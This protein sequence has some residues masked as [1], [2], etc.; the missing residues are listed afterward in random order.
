MLLTE[1]ISQVGAKLKAGSL[2]SSDLCALCLSRAKYI[3][4][5][6]AFVTL[7]NDH[8]TQKAE[9]STARH[10]RGI[11]KGPLDG[12]TLAVKDN[13][14]MKGAPTT[15]CSRMLESF[16][17]QYDATVVRKLQD[18]GAVIIG[19]CNMDEFA[20]G[21][22][23]VDSI[24]GP[25]KN[26]WRSELK[27]RLRQRRPRGET[28]SES[29]SA[30]AGVHEHSPSPSDP[31]DWFISGGSSGG[32]AVAVACGA[33]FAGIGSDTGGSTRNPAAYCGLVG[34]KPS[35]GLVSRHGLIPLVNSMDVPGILAR[36]VDDAAF[37]LGAVAGLDDLDSTTVESHCLS[38]PS[39]DEV[40][41]ERITVGIPSE[42]RCAGLSGDVLE[43]WDS[44]A[45]LLEESGAKVVQVSMPHTQLS[46]ACYSVLNQCEV[47]SNMARYDGIEFGLRVEGSTTEELFASTRSA[48]FNDV[49]RAR[50]LVGNYFLLQRNY[51]KYFVQAQ[52]IR[53][54]IARDF[55]EVWNSGVDV[56]LT[57]TTLT[58]APRY[59]EFVVDDN[60]TQCALQDYCTQPA[61]MAGV[62]A[63]TVPVK[64]SKNG[65]PVSLQLMA[66]HLRDG[67]LLTVAR[68]LERRVCFPVLELE[69]QSAA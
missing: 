12:I 39:Q 60:R 9:E 44:V 30:A 56:L 50:I 58:T 2:L 4:P 69:E 1:S 11:R 27:Y 36:T 40:D 43:A 37:V 15:C 21:S 33:A 34:L 17:P 65:L 20:M 45:N 18:A 10:R 32:S 42:Y 53:S 23:T 47:A 26:V 14:C 19:K 41:V 8:A 49:V 54:L 63:V 68:W 62:P 67:F 28:T 6:N 29:G 25:T 66:P 55:S 35:Y 13:F 57:P 52:K 3:K 24:F 48:G 46:I 22:G 61:N 31:P 16:K 5:L 64:L 51:E 59:S 38:A 7:L